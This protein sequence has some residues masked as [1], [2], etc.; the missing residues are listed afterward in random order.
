MAGLGD[1][2]ILLFYQEACKNH[3]LPKPTYNSDDFCVDVQ[4]NPEEN[5]MRLK[6]LA[7]DALAW[8]KGLAEQLQGNV[9]LR[10]VGVL[11]VLVAVG[12]GLLEYVV[13]PN[14][15]TPM[16]GIWY[17]WVTLTHVGYGDLVPGSQIGR[18]IAGALMLSGF[19]LFALF[20]AIVT[21]ALVS[22]QSDFSGKGEGRPKVGEQDKVMQDLL[23]E[24]TRLRKRLDAL[25]GK[26]PK[27]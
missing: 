12:G 10:H 21:S 17:A 27:P 15:T 9:Y 3:G 4:L 11:A 13:D 2:V 14:I 26:S 6:E 7:E 20:M 19:G 8:V 18:F 25:E 23:A 1:G 16:D 24:L 22:L 5:G